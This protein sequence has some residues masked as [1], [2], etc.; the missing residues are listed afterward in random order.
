MEAVARQILA[1]NVATVVFPASAADHDFLGSFQDASSNDG[2]IDELE[3]D[4][5]GGL[6]EFV[7]NAHFGPTKFGK[8]RQE[9]TPLGY[10]IRVRG[11][12]AF[13]LSRWYCN[14]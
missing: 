1:A 10:G 6:V 3:L 14:V 11:G 9:S 4:G 2:V 5:W 13:G 7:D 12:D 8:P